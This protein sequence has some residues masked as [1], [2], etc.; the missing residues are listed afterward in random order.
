MRHDRSVAPP[1][2]FVLATLAAYTVG[3]DIGAPTGCRGLLVGTAG[4][5]DVTMQS[6][7]A[8]DLVPL[9]AGINWGRFGAIRSDASN[10]AADIWFV[11]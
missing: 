8:R 10:T 11:V 7:E 9:Q 5:Q 6:G 4:A 1:N 2:D 3:A